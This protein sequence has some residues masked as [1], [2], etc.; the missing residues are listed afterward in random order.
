MHRR[1][2]HAFAAIVSAFPI[3]ALSFACACNKTAPAA[4]VDEA[5]AASAS[6]APAAAAPPPASLALLN[7]F[8]GEIDGTLKEA[9]S[10]TAPVPVSLLVKGDKFRVDLPEQLARRSGSPLGAPSYVIV[11]SAAKKLYMV[12]DAQK[13]VLFFDLN[14]APDM[15]KSLGGSTGGPHGRDGGAP[16]A[17]P[18]ITKTGQFDTVAGYRCENWDVASDHRDATVCVANEG[19]SWFSL[20]FGGDAP[21]MAWMSDLLDGKHFPLRATGYDKDGK[22]ETSRVEV[23]KVEKKTLPDDEFQL[24]QGYAVV[25]LGKMLQGMAGMATGMHAMPRP[26]ALKP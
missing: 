17:P 22:T 19:A 14:K 9:K 6:A 13:Q 18:K 11:D 4:P 5:G 12:L 16:P 25:D 20:P 2:A 24:P 26:P 10:A 21:E 23:T 15:M 8:E 7:G 3:G 1:A